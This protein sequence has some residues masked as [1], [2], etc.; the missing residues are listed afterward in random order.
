MRSLVVIGDS[1]GF[2]VGDEDNAHPNKGVG[3][4]LHK[5]LVNFSSY[6]NYSRP[7]ARMRE[8]F[9]IQLPKALEHEPHVVVLIAGGNDVLRQNFDPDDIYWSMYGIVTTLRKRGAEVLTMKLHDPNRKIRLPRRLARL[10]HQ[11]VELLNRIIDDVSGTTGA[12]CLDVRRIETAYDQRVWHIDRMHPNR[13]GYHMLAR[14]FAEMLH[15][16]GHDVRDVTAPILRPRSRKENVKWMLRMGLPWFL[17][18]C[19]DLFPGVGYL[20]VLETSKDAI[21][22]LRKRHIVAAIRRSEHTLSHFDLRSEHSRSIEA[23]QVNHASSSL[24]A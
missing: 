8:V 17:K 9:E 7:G 13:I 15:A 18:R 11:R 24:A 21:R 6:A 4:F 3:A 22:A 19:K 14:H 5:A 10:L 23:H 2:G 12:Q 16:C 20:L 1:V